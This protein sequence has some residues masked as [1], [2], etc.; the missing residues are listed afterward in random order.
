MQVTR[1]PYGLRPRG[2]LSHP[3]TVDIIQYPMRTEAEKLAGG[4]EDKDSS[5]GTGAFP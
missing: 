4:G 5:Q 3:S 2:M 1:V